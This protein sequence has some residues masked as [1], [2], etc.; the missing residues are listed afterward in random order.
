MLIDTL[1]YT[2]IGLLLLQGILL[3]VPPIVI[4][5]NEDNWLLK[6]RGATALNN[7]FGVLINKNQKHYHPVLAQ[8]LYECES[9]K[10]LI[11]LIKSVVSKNV[12]RHVE[13]TG[14]AIT[15]QMMCQMDRSLKFADVR[16]KRAEYISRNY[17]QFKGWTPKSV[18]RLMEMN[19]YEAQKW[20]DYYLE[21]FKHTML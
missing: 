8:E 6:K 16:Y 12:A 7:P 17:K 14:Q 2:P 21:E 1:I 20:T 18:E 13:A 19:N 5:T 15:I 3:L 9:R 11:T 4:N 10:S